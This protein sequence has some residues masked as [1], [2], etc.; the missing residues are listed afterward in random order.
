MPAAAAKEKAGKEKT[1]GMTVEVGYGDMMM[2]KSW[3]GLGGGRSESPHGVFW[4]G[5]DRNEMEEREPDRQTH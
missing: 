4:L 2:K 5:K 1:K 3:R